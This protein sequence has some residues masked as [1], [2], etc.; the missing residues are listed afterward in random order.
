MSGSAPTATP[1]IG[2]DRRSE[3]PQKLAAKADATEP[4]STPQAIASRV[5]EAIK[6][7]AKLKDVKDIF[8]DKPNKDYKDDRD[9]GT[10]KTDDKEVDKDKETSDKGDDKEVDKDKEASDKGDDDKGDDDK[11]DDDKGD[12]DKG[13]DDK[14]DDDKGDDDEGG[15]KDGDEDKLVI[16]LPDDRTSRGHSVETGAGIEP[17]GGAGSRPTSLLKRPPI[18]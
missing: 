18:V 2:G 5:A 8:D 14:G 1:F 6:E 11:G 9:R 16:E 4:A 7:P 15:G 17:A 12:D 13:D 10:H 3:I